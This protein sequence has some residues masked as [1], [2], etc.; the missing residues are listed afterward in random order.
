MEITMEM[1]S[2]VSKPCEDG[3]AWFV[4]Q[5]ETDMVKL[6]KLAIEDGYDAMKYANWGL[7]RLITREQRIKYACFSALQ[8]SFLWKKRDPKRFAVWK[9]W[10]DDG[11]PE[12]SRAA[13]DASDAADAA[14][15]AAASAAYTAYTASAAYAAYAAYAASAY[16][17]APYAAYGAASYAADAASAATAKSRLLAKIIRYGVKLLLE[18]KP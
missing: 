15:S 14:A 5:K 11:C 13:A 17:D 10:V 16:G 3:A 18:K 4:K 8:V 6:A 12:G 2:K 7:T 1:L 9:K